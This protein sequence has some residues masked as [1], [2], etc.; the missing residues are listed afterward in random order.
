M[1]VVYVIIS[2]FSQSFFWNVLD[3]LT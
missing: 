2:W 3:L 1:V